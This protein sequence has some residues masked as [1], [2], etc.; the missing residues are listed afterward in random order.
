MVNYQYVPKFVDFT[1]EVFARL[2]PPLDRV[3]AQQKHQMP[4]CILDI[5]ELH[6]GVVAPEILNISPER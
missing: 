3:K 4:F 2:V 1:L 5:D 6:Q